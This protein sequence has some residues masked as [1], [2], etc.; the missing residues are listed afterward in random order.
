VQT[1]DLPTLYISHTE[2]SV[3]MYWQGVS[4]CSIQKQIRAADNSKQAM[5]IKS[6][7]AHGLK[8]QAISIFGKQLLSLVV[9][10]SLARLLEPSAFGLVALVGVYLGIVTMFVDQGIGTALI[11]R[12][13]LKPE[14]MD[15]AF[16]FNLGCAVILCLATMLLAGPVSALFKEP[17]LIPLLRWSSLGL[18]IGASSA[19]HATLFIKAL[20]F[21]RPVLR[22][23]TANAVGGAAGVGMALAGC[24][25]WSLVGQQLAGEAAGAVFLW[26]MSTYRPSMKFSPS[27]FR[28]LL[29]VS[30]SVFTAS[31]LWFFSTRLDQIIIGRF[32]GI[33]TLGLYTIAGKMPGLANTMAQQP[34]AIVSLPSLSRLQDDHAQMRRA[35]FRGME[36]NAIVSFAV[37]VGLAAVASDLVPILFGAKWA[38]A[39]VLCS[40][41]SLFSL[42]EALQ[43]FCY[44]VLLA[45]GGVGKYV[46]LNIWHL[47]GVLA[48]CLGGIQFGV[49]YL[50]LGL[51]ANSIVIAIPSLLFLRQRIG[52]SPLSYCKP[53]LVPALASLFMAGTVWI[54][55]VALPADV[56]PL[57]RLACKMVGGGATY[58]GCIVLLAPATLRNLVSTI[59][60]AFNRSNVLAEAPTA[61]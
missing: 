1:L 60:H 55:T 8:W 50:V 32:A 34:V 52:M 38:A 31:I 5:N 11:Q 37:F 15:A 46:W 48:V 44:P 56:A 47:V 14:H 19:I 40:F 58:L 25:V 18:V 4:G 27:H 2:N 36:L 7:V 28:D 17:R 3:K 13:D 20:D 59:S 49:N 53:C 16:W 30:S 57:L 29:G 41:L 43:V 12:K 22:N 35:V 61:V 10:T 23:L 42:V 24:G 26:N 45:S 21:R 9:F 33:P 6:Q 39:A 54:V 51:I